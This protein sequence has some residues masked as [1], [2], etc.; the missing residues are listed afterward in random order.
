MQKRAEKISFSAKSASDQ[1]SQASE[2]VKNKCL[3]N[4]AELLLKNKSIIISDNKKDLKRGRKEGLS[5]AMLDR[6]AVDKERLELMAEGLSQVASLPDPVGRIDSGWKRPNGLMISKVR[7]PLGVIF[8][9]YESRP[10][11]TIDAGS[12]AL[13]SGNAVILRGGKEAI[14]SNMALG[15]VL[16]D[17]LKSVKLNKDSVQV[18]DTPD[19]LFANELLKQDRYIDVVIPRGGK[20]LIKAVLE[21]STIPVISHLDG[22]CHVFVDKDADLKMA[23]NISVN[24][25]TQRT[26]VCNAMETLLVD[27]KIAAKFIPLCFKELRKKKVKILGCKE[28]LRY[29]KNI[30]VELA[31]EEDWATE[32]LDNV[33]SVKIVK[34]VAGAVAHINNYGSNHTDS[35]V[36]GNFETANTFKRCVQSSSVMVN[37]STRFSDG[38]E[39]GFGA[40]IGISTNKLHARGPVGLDELTT[41]KFI[42]EGNGN[43]RE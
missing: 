13:K 7:I 37:A 20:G 3:Y 27:K 43:I 26:G 36:T 28:T 22:I 2:S 21:N 10:N 30:K 14:N 17:A 39:Y 23:V 19:R 9:I 16:S 4:A 15:R 34:D 40:E 25:K 11:V 24:A 41:Y 31:S 35:I 29:S 38:F 12:L 33:L 5:S 1:L 32:Y 6:L 8:M 18:I 42:V